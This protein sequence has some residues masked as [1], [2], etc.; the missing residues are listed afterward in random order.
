V[1]PPLS[2][3]QKE[4]L[5]V[6]IVLHFAEA[7][8][9]LNAE[10]LEDARASLRALFLRAT[11][12]ETM[13]RKVI[14]ILKVN[15]ALNK[16]FGDMARILDG[17]K[18]SHLALVSK[19]DGLKQQLATLA[20][21]PEENAGF[22]GPLVA[23]SAE[24]VRTVGEF[25]RQMSEFK[26]AKE[27]EA[28]HAHI[29][30]LAQEARERLR[31]RFEK[32]AAEENQQEKQVKKKVI[33]AFNLSEAESDYQYS[34]RSAM[35]L[36]ADIENSLADFQRMCQLA[37]RPE[38]RNQNL[39]RSSPGKA[40]ETDIYA[41]AFKALKTFPRLQD[42]MP[43]VQELLRLYQRSFGLFALDFDRFNNALAPMIENT[44][45]YFHAKEQDEDV[46]TQQKKLLLIEALIAFI[47]EVSLLLRDGQAYTYPKF[48]G[49]VSSQIARTGTKWSAIAEQLLE[50]KVAAEAELTTQLV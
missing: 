11:G 49:V 19:H 16:T 23:Y 3:Q 5:L 30:R 25:E 50:T 31:N 35:S 44:E 39:V 46:R 47:E 29:L 7:H 18:K 10:Q 21:T 38:M 26:E 41:I 42:L 17:I 34:K 27:T 6:L 12:E 32:G 2:P 14:G 48:S 40:G 28:R 45:E 1:L 37:M 36:R 22:I 13:L 9:L 15:R 43:A 20:I 33:Q 24:F 8:D 4:S